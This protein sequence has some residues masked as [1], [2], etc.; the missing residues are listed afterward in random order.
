VVRAGT[1]HTI[2]DLAVTGGAQ[3]SRRR[4]TDLR[5]ALDH[6]MVVDQVARR[7][8]RAYHRGRRPGLGRRRAGDS[9]SF[10]HAVAEYVKDG[11]GFPKLINDEMIVLFYLANGVSFQEAND[12]AVAGCV[13]QRIPNQET[14]VTPDTGINYGGAIEATVMFVQTIF[15]Y[16]QHKLSP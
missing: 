10:L 11:C 16:F 1:T 15:V 3:L 7:I 2:I 6:R 5:K 4:D 14:H 12:Y 9:Y 8:C 13:E